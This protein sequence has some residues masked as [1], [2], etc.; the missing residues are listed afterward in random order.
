M[1]YHYGINLN[2]LQFLKEPHM[3]IAREKFIAIS[4]TYI[5]FSL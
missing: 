2:K 1:V 4:T 3:I 5:L